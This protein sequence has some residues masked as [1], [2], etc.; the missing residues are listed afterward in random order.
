M[1]QLSASCSCPNWTMEPEHPASS[2]GL[3]SLP[4]S[5]APST[6]DRQPVLPV[7]KPVESQAELA[8]LGQVSRPRLT[9]VMNLL[10]LAPE[11]QE[12]VLFHPLITT[13]RDPVNCLPL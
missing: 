6:G 3:P 4:G 9:Q 12:Q 10:H 7:R 1:S 8:R 5:F 2:E 11:I 13:G